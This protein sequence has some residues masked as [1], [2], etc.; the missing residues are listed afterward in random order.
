M[1]TIL[2][3]AN[4]F[5]EIEALTVVDILRRG[6]VECVICSINEEKVVEGAH[7][8]SCVADV[9]MSQLLIEGKDDIATKYNAVILPGGQPG[10]NNLMNNNLVIDIVKN[11]YENDKVIAAIC[12][13]P[14]VLEAAG[15]TK[16]KKITSF[17]DVLK[18][19]SEAIYTAEM[20]T[21]DGN[22]ITGRGPGAA[23][24]F[25]FLILEALGKEEVVP[26]LRNDMFF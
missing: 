1:K 11:M 21:R 5:E 10:T 20:V 24:D 19:Q 3:L 25:A 7:G 14:M 12:A 6:D 17:P 16:G 2:F 13:A 22:I 23:A 4:G 9:N 26:Q 15:L 8:I 18:R